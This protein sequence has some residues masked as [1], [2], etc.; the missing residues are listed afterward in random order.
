MRRNALGLDARIPK[1]LRE[2][3]YPLRRTVVAVG[4]QVGET[5]LARP[6]LPALALMSL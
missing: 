2:R 4:G 6:R 3:K 5:D 1:R